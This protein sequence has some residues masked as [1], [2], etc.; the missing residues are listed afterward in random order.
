MCT[1]T[2]KMQGF[3]SLKCPSPSSEDTCVVV[4]LIAS[5]P[6]Y[7]TVYHTPWESYLHYINTS[8]VCKL[9]YVGLVGIFQFTHK[10]T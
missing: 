3:G 1:E 2:K 9:S 8:V 7:K 10:H 4:M 5:S 6:V